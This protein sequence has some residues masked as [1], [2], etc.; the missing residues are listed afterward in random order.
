MSG[1]I[2]MQLGPARKRLS[3]RLEESMLVM[4]NEDITKMKET[5]TKLKANI[6]SHELLINS[7]GGVSIA[8]EEE[9]TIIE[10]EMGKSMDLNLDANEVLHRMNEHIEEIE[11]GERKDIFDT[12]MKEKQREKLVRE[13]EKLKLETEHTRKQLEEPSADVANPP[14]VSVNFFRKVKLPQLLLPTFSGIITEWP[15]FWDSFESTI[16]SDS[17]L[18][19]VDKFKYLMTVL[20]G[21]ARDTLS[22]FNLSEIQYDQAV[23][24]LRERYDDKEYIIH[25]Y[26]SALSDL[27]KC[28]NVT[29]ELRRTFNFI[30]IQLRSLESMGEN[31]NNNYIVALI[32]AKLP[33]AFNLKLEEC[34]EGDWGVRET[35]EINYEV[36]SSTRAI[37]FKPQQHG[38][39]PR[40]R[41]YS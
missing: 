23:E 15:T 2:R 20:E 24:H 11:R 36:N 4:A 28:D 19:K 3:D 38:W 34:R 18:S 7:L 32:K 14:P 22:G 12:E 16:H 40:V 17:S 31:V 26:Y 30:E 5:R 39:L 35:R 33:D 25:H 21:E 6:V 13:I 41:M 1:G 29:S 27:A 9:H 37:R 8:T 10:K